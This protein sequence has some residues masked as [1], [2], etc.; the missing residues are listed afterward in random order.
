MKFL[1]AME[2]TPFEAPEVLEQHI[3]TEADA[4][5]VLKQWMND[6]D[7]FTR[8]EHETIVIIGIVGSEGPSDVFALIQKEKK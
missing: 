4:R 1:I 3:G 2:T 8:E 6:D 7:R 5:R